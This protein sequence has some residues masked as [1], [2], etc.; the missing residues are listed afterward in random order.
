MSASNSS[1]SAGASQKKGE[2]DKKEAQKKMSSAEYYRKKRKE[3]ERKSL[4]NTRK[5]LGNYLLNQDCTPLPYKRE[6]TFKI[7]VAG[8]YGVG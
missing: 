3:Q 1:S 8:D 4:E 6:I 7:I 5:N 2:S